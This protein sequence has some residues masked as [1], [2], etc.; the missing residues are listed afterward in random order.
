MPLSD[1]VRFELTPMG[2]G[3]VPEFGSV[4]TLAGFEDLLAMSAYHH[5]SEAVRYPAVMLTTGFNDPV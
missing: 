3:N 5:V 1:A 2:P 4:R